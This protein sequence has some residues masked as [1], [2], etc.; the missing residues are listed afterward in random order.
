MS[1][2]RVGQIQEDTEGALIIED[3]MTDVPKTDEPVIG[4]TEEIALIVPEMIKD[5]RNATEKKV[6]ATEGEETEDPI[7]G[8]I[9][10]PKI[11]RRIGNH[12]RR[13]LILIRA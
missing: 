4:E 8:R 7:V 11:S 2:L 1:F 5:E 12:C 9:R 3:P 6:G 13:C 10:D